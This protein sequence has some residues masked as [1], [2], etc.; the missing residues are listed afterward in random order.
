MSTMRRRQCRKARKSEEF[1]SRGVLLSFGK[2]P[3]MS[4]SWIKWDSRTL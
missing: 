2:S 3:V 4:E 1:Y